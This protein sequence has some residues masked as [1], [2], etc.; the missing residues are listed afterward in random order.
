MRQLQVH[1]PILNPNITPT[2]LNPCA[3]QKG[4]NKQDG[5]NGMDANTKVL[6]S[7]LEK[8]GGRAERGLR[9]YIRLNGMMSSSTQVRNE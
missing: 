7:G 3:K 6:L 5:R 2:Y 1:N 9:T 8:L 4:D